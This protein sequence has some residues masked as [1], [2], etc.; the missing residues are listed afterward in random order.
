MSRIEQALEKA[1]AMRKERN[2]IF[3]KDL[4]LDRQGKPLEITAV[5]TN[6]PY[7][8]TLQDPKSAVSEEYRKLKSVIVRLTRQEKFGNVI[9][10]TSSISNEG[11]SITALNLAISLAQEYDS[12]ALIMEADL[13]R[14]SLGGYLNLD[15]KTGWTDYMSGDIDLSA[16]L[17][18]TDI[19][20]LTYLPAGSK[21]SNPVEWFSSTRIK[22]L[23]SELKFRYDDRYIIIDTTPV[24][25]FAETHTVCGFADG[26]VFIVGE[27]CAS[28]E[29]IREALDT[30]NDVN[31]L[32]LVYNNASNISSRGYYR[33]DNGSYGNGKKKRDNDI[34][35]NNISV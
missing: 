4:R 16:A 13:R 20:N 24:L 26:I 31:I 9:A 22:E 3:A 23:I 28:I 8:V 7:I 2:G 12:T 27:G 21:V 15:A 17:I 5:S 6:N 30:L 1:T 10:V 18:R 19:G 25:P 29:E 14:P 34:C 11:K 35:T 33:Y 32:G